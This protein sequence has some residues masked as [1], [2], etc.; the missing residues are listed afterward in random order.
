MS[1]VVNGEEQNPNGRSDIHINFCPV[2]ISIL[3]VRT[4][5]MPVGYG[6]QYRVILYGAAV[7]DMNRNRNQTD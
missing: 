1:A 7:L 6:I 4:F 2:G 3:S 5:G